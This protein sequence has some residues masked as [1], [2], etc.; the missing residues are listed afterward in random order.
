MPVYFFRNLPLIS[1]YQPQIKSMGEFI[2]RRDWL[3]QSALAA[4]GLGISLRSL[5]GEDYLPRNF[6]N[7]KGLI[8]LGANENPY[9]I[10]PKARQAIIDMLGESNRYQ[11]N[12]SSLQSLKN[13]LAAYYGLSP[14]QILITAGSGEGLVL[15]ARYFSKGNIIAANPTFNIL[16]NA[17][18]R[19]STPVIEIP[20]TS[21]KVND[22]SGM[23]AAINSNTSLVYIVNPNNPTGTIVKPSALKS[24]CEE[25]CKKTF[26]LIDEAYID[27]VDAP[28][29][30]SMTGL[31]EKN[32]NLIVMRT[33]SKIHGM[34]GLR[35]GFIAGQPGSISK[36][37]ENYFSNSR[38]CVSNLTMAAALASLKDE[39]HRKT[40]KEKND[41]ARAYTINSL[42]ELKLKVTPSYT[43]FI[44]FDLGT[45]KGDFGKDML[46]KNILL[47]SNSDSDG[48]WCRVSVGTMD[49]MKIF[50][51]TMKK[52]FSM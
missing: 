23:L 12:V 3:K 40:C 4:V 34:A 27:F 21:G 32:P 1:Y 26:V 2:H 17:A 25:A 50:V 20:L 29:N 5:A 15:L 9:G 14:E 6:G 43:N 28:D 22:L 36:L 16:Q 47:R 51:N 46:E 13:D 18:K 8:N 11:F 52:T 10:S 38:Y 33:F 24:F 19:I 31:I 37:E 39:G 49:E 44:F 48:K 41:A 7:E 30:E 42:Q 45:Y 35:I